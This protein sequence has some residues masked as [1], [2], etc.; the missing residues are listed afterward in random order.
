MKY[1][2][3][4]STPYTRRALAGAALLVAGTV[5]GPA[6]A[7][8]GT[9]RDASRARSVI[10]LVGDG[11]GDSE[12]TLARN[13]TVGAGGRLHMDGFPMTG[14]YTTCS[15]DRDGRPN[16]VTDSAASATTWATG[17]KTVNDRISKTA[18]DRAVP[19]IL[20]LA[21]QGGLVTGSVTTAELTDATPAALTSH[22][23]HRSCQGPADMERCPTDTRAA[24]GPGSITEQTVA[25][26]GDVLLGGG[27]QRFDQTITQGPERGATV[28][29]R[30]RQH[31]YRVATDARDLDAVRPGRPVLGLFAPEELPVAW[32]RTPAAVG[33][34]ASQRCVTDREPS[35]DIPSL[36]ALT[37][38][39]IALLDARARQGAGKGFFLQVEGASIDKQ[40][41]DAD[42]C[43]QI[44]ETV[45]FDQAVKAARE[46]AA[47]HPDTLVI[48]TADHRHSSQIVPMAARPAGLSETLITDE[49]APMKVSYGTHAGEE[50]QEHSGVQVRIAAEGPEA[51]RVLGTTD[52]TQLFTTLRIAPNLQ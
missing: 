9:E 47:R 50:G 38:K 39:A 30:A 46:Y 43:G 23:T 31:G 14:M 41:H 22:V 35:D 32:T 20:E 8:R 52:Q 49:G 11:M 3:T 42:P 13:Y 12:I 2:V 44:G 21:R 36:E 40:N 29:E 25:H 5:T 4:G 34:T 15:V 6:A 51:H 18:D 48:A 24:G 45:A 37:R 17:H 10:L 1:M 26:R 16:Y 27:R 28:L 33:G 7:L 19:T